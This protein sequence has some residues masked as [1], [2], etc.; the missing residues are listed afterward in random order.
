MTARRDRENASAL[1]SREENASPFASFN[2][3]VDQR[4]KLN[5][6]HESSVEMEAALAAGS[7]S[8]SATKLSPQH[9]D[10]HIFSRTFDSRVDA[11]REEAEEWKGGA[12]TPLNEVAADA[13]S[14][15]ADELVFGRASLAPGEPGDITPSKSSVVSVPK[16]GVAEEKKR[17]R[18]KPKIVSKR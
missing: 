14:R 8:E 1:V 10:A 13:L 3:P 18:P 16:R 6:T 12:E 4:R 7:G 5:V 11:I 17:I 9:E 2:W 15:T